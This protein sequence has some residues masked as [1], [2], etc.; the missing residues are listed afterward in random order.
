M[1]LCG[2]KK[3]TFC[4]LGRIPACTR[5]TRRSLCEI[6]PDSQRDAVLRGYSCHSLLEQTQQCASVKSLS[7]SL[8]RFLLDRH[9]LNLTQMPKTGPKMC[10]WLVEMKFLSAKK[11]TNNQ[12]NKK[13]V[14]K[15]QF[16]HVSWQIINLFSIS[17]SCTQGCRGCCSLSQL[18]GGGVTAWTSGRFIAGSHRKNEPFALAPTPLGQF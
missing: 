4:M 1:C 18:S 10:R 6:P 2:Q 9:H 12:T 15:T 11:Q 14:N 17:F 16:F 13:R 8:F 3:P 5:P 7:L